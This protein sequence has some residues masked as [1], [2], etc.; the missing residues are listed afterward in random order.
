MNLE[1]TIQIWEENEKE[2]EDTIQVTGLLC[3]KPLNDKGR[4]Q[5]GI[6]SPWTSRIPL[7]ETVKKL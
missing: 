4:H 6:Y 5:P 2:K 7:E 1:R 3:L